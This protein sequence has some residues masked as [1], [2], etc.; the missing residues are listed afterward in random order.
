MCVNTIQSE[1]YPPENTPTD[2]GPDDHTRTY[3]W[4]LRSIILLRI[5]SCQVSRESSL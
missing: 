2:R 3:T 4:V 5:P 1:D